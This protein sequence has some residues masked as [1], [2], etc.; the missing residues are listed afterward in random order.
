VPL[1]L[2]QKLFNAAPPKS[3]GGIPKQQVL[4]PNC[5][6]NDLYNGYSADTKL[7]MDAL[8]DFLQG[9]QERAKKTQIVPDER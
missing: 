4:L 9:V 1:V 8:R 7:V 3:A 2:G 5:E 6:H